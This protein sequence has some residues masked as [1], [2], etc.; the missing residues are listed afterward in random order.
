[1][2]GKRTEGKAKAHPIKVTQAK[3]RVTNSNGTNHGKRKHHKHGTK[4]MQAEKVT[5]ANTNGN[6]MMM[7]ADEANQ[8]K[9]TKT[10]VEGT[11]LM[12]ANNVTFARSMVT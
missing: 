10:K 5:K 2:K 9:V 12:Q 3:E 4:D 11:N 1:M 6:P 7:A 8:T